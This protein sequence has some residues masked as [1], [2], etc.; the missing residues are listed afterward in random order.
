MSGLIVAGLR[1]GLVGTGIDVVD[2]ID[3]TLRPGEIVGLVGES[4]SGKT[5]VGTALLAYARDGAEIEAGQVLLA[6]EDVLAKPW[7]EVRDLRGTRLAYVPQDPAAA[8]NPSIRI[9][10]QLVELMELRNM[11]TTPSRL[12]DARRGLVEVGLP[13]TD[14][15]LRRY[16]HQLSGG[17]VQRVALAMA[18]MPRPDVL[19]LDEP[20]TGL[21]VTTQGMV[22]DTIAA[23]CE[24]H[25]VAA[26]YVTHDLAV[27]ANI[28]DRVAVMYAGRIAELGPREAVFNDP[29]HPYTRMLLDAIP[30]LSHARALKGIPGSTPAPGARPA[31]CRFSDRCPEVIEACRT[32]E[33]EPVL[34]PAPGPA[35]TN[36]TESGDKHTSR[37]LRALELGTWDI[38]TGTVADADPEKPRTTLLEVSGLNVFYGRKQVIHDVS[39]DVATAEVV[40]LVGES[41]SGKTTIAR[42]IGGLHRQWSGTISFDREELAKKPRGRRR[43]QRKRIQYIFQNPYLSLNPRHTVERIVRRPIDLFGIA[44]GS[45][46]QDRVES[47]LASVALGSRTMRLPVSR[48]SG[49]ER[50]RVAI[51][52]ALAAEADLLV[53]DEITSALDVSV[54]GSIVELLEEL[55]LSRGISAVFVTHNLALVR[56][57]AVRIEILSQGRI[58][59]SGPVATV[60]EEP[61]EAYTQQLLASTPT[62]EPRG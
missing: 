3:L 60:M 59:E 36:G 57:I 53:C 1:V 27:I 52:R 50:Q 6:G 10:R 14:E 18:F 46:A 30:H 17:Q 39:F 19:V 13:D 45:E 23:L 35:D 42:C 37:C 41:G 58:V 51:A 48:L 44:S 11:G 55:R 54:Q 49:G 22:L 15:F 25:D 33:P 26:L 8:L 21:D 31:G 28:A 38:N 34:I 32:Q 29:R 62:I 61:R 4:G 43:D 7:R 20:T 12:E 5:T 16:P 56:S 9:G 24:S 2:D 40:A 47:L